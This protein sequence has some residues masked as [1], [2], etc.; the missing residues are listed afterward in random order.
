MIPTVNCH[1]SKNCF[2]RA[3]CVKCL[4]DHGT[5]ACTRN[6]ETDGPSACVLCNSSG[7]TANYLGYPQDPPKNTSNYTSTEDIKVL[8]SVITSIDIG[9]LALFAKKFQVATNPVE[10]IIVFAEHA[11]LVEAIKNNKI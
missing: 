4:G 8:L 1:S 7:H 5:A 3:R 10:K 11:S 9:A 2:Q 6:K